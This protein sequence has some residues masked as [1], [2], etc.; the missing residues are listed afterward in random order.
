MKM[1]RCSPACCTIDDGWAHWRVKVVDF[2]LGDDGDKEND[3]SA[4]QTRDNYFNSTGLGF[5]QLGIKTII[6]KNSLPPCKTALYVNP[7]I[8]RGGALS[9]KIPSIRRK[10]LLLCPLF[11]YHQCNGIAIMT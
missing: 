9:W 8:I 5:K 11:E 10:F 4:Y 3:R 6:S 2:K 1:E 7:C